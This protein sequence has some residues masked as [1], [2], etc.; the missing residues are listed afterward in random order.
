ML[1]NNQLRGVLMAVVGVIILSPDSLILRLVQADHWTLMFWRGL[2][3]GVVFLGLVFWHHP[4]DFF[5]SFQKMGKAGRYVCLFYALNAM[6]FVTAISYTSVA[7]ALLIMSSGPLFAAI[8]TALFLHEQVPMRTWLASIFGFGGIAIIFSGSFGEGRL[9]GDICAL[10]SAVLLAATFVVLRKRND[11]VEHS[12]G[13]AGLLVAALVWPFAEP[14]S[15]R[16][17][18]IWLLLCL[19]L[20]VIPASFFLL[21]RAPA[22]IPAAEVSLIMLLEAILGP[23]LVWLAVA[24]APSQLTFLGGALLLTTLLIHSALS[25]RSTR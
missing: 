1:A 2:I 5:N 11:F 24:E 25:F 14:S 16:F 9:L 18:D 4:R 13:L 10:G 17:E 6:C 3:S 12:M 8:F 21:M 15:I 19:G 23:L 22:Y 20:I 7:N